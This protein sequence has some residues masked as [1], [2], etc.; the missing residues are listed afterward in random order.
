MEK[1][2][3]G[4]KAL[5]EN[6]KTKSALNKLGLET[7][8]EPVAQIMVGIKPYDLY[9]K[10]KAI[11]KTVTMIYDGNESK[12]P[13]ALYKNQIPEN[14]KTKTELKRMKL[15]PVEDAI[16]V[17]KIGE[18]QSIDLYDVA[19]AKPLT[20]QTAVQNESGVY[21]CDWDAIPENL[22]T[23]GALAKIG[24]VPAL[25]PVAQINKNNAFY[26]LYDI[27]NIVPM[28]NS[29]KTDWSYVERNWSNNPNDYIILNIISTGQGQ[30][31]EAIQLSIVDLYGNC[32]TNEYFK[33][34]KESNPSYLKKHKIGEQFLAKYPTWA[35]RWSDISNMLKDKI[36]FMYNSNQTEL[37][38]KQTCKK[39]NIEL[40]SELNIIHINS[41]IK[42]KFNVHDLEGAMTY[43]KYPFEI[44]TLHNSLIDCFMCLF[45]I[46]K[47]AELFKIKKEALD[48][49]DN[50]C[51]HKIKDGDKD[52]YQKGYEWIKNTF[53]IK[54]IGSD[55]KFFDLKLCTQIKKS[56][57]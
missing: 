12:C 27:K 41:Y 52:G 57:S 56:L 49:F 21:E 17:I 8:E 22:K 43:L 36:I 20:I 47:N 24:L 50:C 54:N 38:I 28:Q 39:Y 31:D 48:K 16:M 33:A 26:D 11:D 51:N 15:E 53:K 32:I 13:Y 10:N 25:K 44:G 46:N 18:L 37:I 29:R 45:C 40:E 55:F 7:V 4:W 5:P 35:E 14:Y 6:L 2:T 30:D 23:K 19:K 42:Y 3:C 34:E 1:Y 9:D